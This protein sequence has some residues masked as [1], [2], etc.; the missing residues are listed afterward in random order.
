MTG[1]I[2]TTKKVMRPMKQTKKTEES[3]NTE[4]KTQ[5]PQ[6]KQ[7][8]VIFSVVYLKKLLNGENF[9]R[10]VPT[11]INKFFIR[12][13]NEIFYDNGITYDLLSLQEAKMKIPIEYK[14]SIEK[15]TNDKKII[16][17]ISLRQ[18]FENEIFLNS[19]EAKITINYDKEYK[20]TQYDDV[21]GFKIPYVYL[22]MKKNLPRDYNK[23]LPETEF[24]KIGVQKFFHHIKDIICSNNEKE[25]EV[26]IKFLAC[27]IVGVK[28]KICLYWQSHEQSGK[29]TVLNIINKIL[30]D[31]MEKT[32]S[33]ESIE[34]YTKAFEGKTLLNFDELP[35]ANSSTKLL[36][37]RLKSLIT[38]PLFDCRGM[39]S[40]NY[41]QK[42]TFNLVITTNNNAINLSQNNN[43]RYYVNSISNKWCVGDDEKKLEEKKKHFDELY[44]YFD[45]EDVLIGIYQEFIKI[46]DEKVKPT[47]WTG[48]YEEK[49]QGNI[50]KMLEAMPNF[51]KYIKKTYLLNKQDI[52]IKCS[53]LL[54]EYNFSSKSNLS[55]QKLGEYMSDLGAIVKD[56]RNSTGRYRKYVICNDDLLKSFKRL[57]YFSEEFDDFETDEI[58]ENPLEKG[59]KQDDYKTKYEELIKLQEAMQKNYELKIKECEEL[60]AKYEPKPEPEIKPKIKVNNS[61][62]AKTKEE[63]KPEKQHIDLTDAQISECLDSLEF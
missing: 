22:N 44:N 20:Y 54:E 59:I 23:K 51:Y 61:K 4:I 42:N 43:V 60:K 56:V 45:N 34:K 19:P 30:G 58:E 27:C 25:Y 6:I 11:Y 24:I 1:L 55:A 63:L 36:Q 10:D 8:D 16:K 39:Y 12:Y 29:G 62:K 47:K 38:E 2:R 40:A 33:I 52:N 21:R 26:V 7:H 46:Y 13:G 15:T 32:N 14:K 48:A 50:N 5:I 35:I 28:V 3:K 49:T 18:Y 41:I 37:D 17:E 57:N 31:R 9:M 53:E